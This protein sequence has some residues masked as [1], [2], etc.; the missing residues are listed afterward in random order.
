MGPPGEN[1]TYVVRTVL[2]AQLL[3]QIAQNKL[4]ADVQICTHFLWKE[5]VGVA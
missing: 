3:N 1:I 5:M 2:N 4:V